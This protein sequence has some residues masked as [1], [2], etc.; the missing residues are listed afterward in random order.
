[1]HDGGPPLGAERGEVEV[2]PGRREGRVVARLRDDGA[3]AREVDPDVGVR[4]VQLDR[5]RH[6]DQR[7]GAASAAGGIDAADV[8][9][10]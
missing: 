2:V 7:F 9:V 4:A 1:L 8:V 3:A 6:A 10:P 5:A